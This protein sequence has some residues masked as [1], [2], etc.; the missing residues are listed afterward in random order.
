MVTVPLAFGAGVTVTL[1]EEPAPSKTMPP[2]GTTDGFVEAYAAATFNST[3]VFTIT[4][5]P[6][7][8]DLLGDA[9]ARAAALLI[10]QGASLTSS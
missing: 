6:E 5:G 7:G 8:T 10:D 3:L 2:A 9:H 1:R 4:S